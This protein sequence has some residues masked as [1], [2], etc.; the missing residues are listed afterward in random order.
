MGFCQRFLMNCS[1]KMAY[2]SWS[3]ENFIALENCLTAWRQVMWVVN[4]Y[5]LLFLSHNPLANTEG[6][7]FLCRP[8]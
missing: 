1:Y 2:V 4:R 3:C 7:L 8:N 6:K 5:Y